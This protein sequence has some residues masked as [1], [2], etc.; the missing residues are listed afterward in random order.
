MVEDLSLTLKV[1]VSGSLL[2][3]VALRLLEIVV[4]VVRKALFNDFAH[5]DGMNQ[6]LGRLSSLSI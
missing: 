1:S 5:I 2:I 6:R 4:V 3:V